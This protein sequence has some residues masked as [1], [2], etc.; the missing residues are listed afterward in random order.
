MTEAKARFRT[1]RCE[2]GFAKGICE[3]L[4][5]PHASTRAV[6]GDNSAKLVVPPNCSS[7]KRACADAL[8]RGDFVR[9]SNG[10][11]HQYRYCEHC[12]GEKQERDAETAR[13]QH[14][15]DRRSPMR[16]AE[17]AKAAE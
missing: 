15:F 4:M 5:C 8:P 1:E 11:P 16:S 6:R 3:V 13:R 17:R 14:Y 2:H 10:K 9:P 7:C 12:W